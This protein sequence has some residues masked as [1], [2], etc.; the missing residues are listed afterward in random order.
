LDLFIV[1]PE[2][3]GIQFTLRTGCAEFSQRCVTSRSVAGFG[4]L[5]EDCKYIVGETRI[6]RNGV[7]VPLLE[8]KDFFDLLGLGWV[9]P[10]ER[11]KEFRLQRTL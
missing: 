9:E 1:R 11:N 6:E 2:T 10:R 3:W 5:P 4:F 8:E 7:T